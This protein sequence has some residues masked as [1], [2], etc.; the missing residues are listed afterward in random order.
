MDVAVEL[1][2]WENHVEE[3]QCDPFQEGMH[4]EVLTLL[5]VRVLGCELL[6]SEYV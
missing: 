1:S 2:D 5:T 4:H 6:N 3:D